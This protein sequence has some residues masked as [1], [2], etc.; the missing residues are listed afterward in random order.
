[1][2]ICHNCKPPERKLALG[3]QVTSMKVKEITRTFGKKTQGDGFLE[4]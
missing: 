1:M 3:E 4:K 2:P